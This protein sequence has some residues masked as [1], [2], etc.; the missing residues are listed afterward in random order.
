MEHGQPNDGLKM[1]QYGGVTAL[2]IPPDEQR[3]VVVGVSGRAAMQ[4]TV[5][6]QEATALADLDCWDTADTAVAKARE[7]WTPDRADPYAD[8]YGDLDGPAACLALK[9]ERLDAAESFAAA[10]VRRSESGGR[11]RRPVRHRA[12]HRPR[13]GR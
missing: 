12:G 13:P 5:L 10:S 7:L 3:A 8:P 2:D 6:V 9:R 4:A 1:L 11:S